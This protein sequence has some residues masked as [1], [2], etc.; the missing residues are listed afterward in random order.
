ME[1]ELQVLLS[2]AVIQHRV[3][4]RHDGGLQVHLVSVDASRAVQVVYDALE[5]RSLEGMSLVVLHCVQNF[6][7][8]AR[9]E[10]YCAQDLEDGD[11]GFDVF[12]TQ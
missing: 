4:E 10:A 11:F 12:C 5:A 9:N 8:A 2:Q 3:H 1:T 7:V 6:L